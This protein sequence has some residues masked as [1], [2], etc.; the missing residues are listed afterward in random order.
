MATKNR[1]YLIVC[2][3]SDY[4][5]YEQLDHVKEDI[6]QITKLFTK[7]FGYERVLPSLDI[8]PN[9]AKF[10]DY[11]ADSFADWLEKEERQETDIVI[12]YY[13]GHGLNVKGD[14]HYLAL[15]KTE[16]DKEWQTALATEDLVR[17]LKSKKVKISQILFIIDT[18]HSQGGA[19]DVV[20]LAAKIIGS[21]EKVKGN[22][23]QIH[24]IAACRT[25]QLATDGEFSKAFVKALEE[26]FK[27]LEKGYIDPSKIVSKINELIDSEEQNVQYNVVFC[28]QEVKFFPFVPQTIQNWEQLRHQ[29]VKNLV[30][31]LNKK[32]KLSFYAINYFLLSC[33]FIKELLLNELEIEEKLNELSEKRVVDGVCPLIACAEWCKNRFEDEGDQDTVCE[34]KIWQQKAIEYREAKNLAVIRDFIGNA[35][36]EFKKIIKKEKLKLLVIIEPQGSTNNTGKE[37]ESFYMSLFLW[38]SSENNPIGRFAERQLLDLTLI[39]E[40]EISE[41]LPYTLAHNN[42]LIKLIRQALRSLPLPVK[43]DVE[44]LIP[45][46]LF[47]APFD[48]VKFKS[49]Q[50]DAFIGQ[51]YPI[52]INSYERYFDDFDYVEIRNNLWLEK[53]DFWDKAEEI[54]DDNFYFSGS[55]LPQKEELEEID[56]SYSIAIWTRNKKHSIELEKDLKISE[57]KEWPQ[58]VKQL[59]KKNKDLEITLFW[60]DIFPKPQPKKLFSTSFLD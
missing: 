19:S 23:I 22:N 39:E 29:F 46:A 37:T 30:K 52:F 57:W 4:D 17:P 8:N 58:K 49:G 44:F 2:G 36:D 1:Y 11:Q 45:F 40:L 53:D 3:T 33:N 59:R 18:C 26:L 16:P 42:F 15:Q 25:K 31:I 54:T 28:G 43:V 50:K 51:E 10:I 14:R 32:P 47:S 9:K 13:S 12:F 34:I 60:D 48:K 7:R 41:Y 20:S 56:S 5:N 6:E 21:F 35:F 38:I 55:K 24:I 27:D